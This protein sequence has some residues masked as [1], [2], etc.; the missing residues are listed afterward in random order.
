MTIALFKEANKQ[1]YNLIHA[2]A[3]LAGIPAWIVGKLL[4]IPVIYTVHGSIHL[5]SGRKNIYYYIEQF[6]ICRLPY[7]AQIFVSHGTLQYPNRNKNRLV[8]HN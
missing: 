4:S 8:I 2:H 6:L 1:H 5:D 7:A 3:L